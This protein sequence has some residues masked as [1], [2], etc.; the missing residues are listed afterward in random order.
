MK[1]LGFFLKNMATIVACFAVFLMLSGCDDKDPKR[2]TVT[3]NSNEGSAVSPQ[4]VEEGKRATKPD[5]PTRN[6]YLFDAWYKEASLTNQWNFNVDAVTADI[7]LHANWNELFS[8]DRF[9]A[10]SYDGSDKIKYS[11]SFSGYDFY[12]IYLG[13]MSN[14]PLFSSDP[15]FHNGM[16]S[17]LTFSIS[18]TTTSIIEETISNSSETVLMT[19]DEHTKSKTTGGRLSAETGFKIPIINIGAKT[20]AESHWQNFISNTTTTQ[21]QQT[22]SLTNTVTH[23]TNHAS[24]FTQTHRFT[25]GRDAKRGYYQYTLFGASDVYLFVIRNRETGARELDYKE[26][27]KPNTPITPRNYFWRLDYSETGTFGK[28]DQSEFELDLSILENLPEPELNFNK[29]QVSNTI[30][31]NNALTFIRDGGSDVEYT[32]T[33]SGNVAVPG[34]VTNSF[35]D[36]SNL[37]VTINSINNGKLFLN[38]QGSILRIGNGQTVNL[39]NIDL[40]GLST[41]QNGSTVNNNV[42]A[43]FI[44]GGNVTM[45]GGSIKG[46]SSPN[47]NGGGVS[48]S[49]GIL[50]IKGSA[51]ITGN[52]AE[53]GGGV[54]VEN[55]G[56]FNMLDDSSI[57]D[58]IANLGGG[59]YVH[60][61]GIFNMQDNTSLHKNIAQGSLGGGGVRI[62]GGSFRIS[63]GVVYGNNAGDMSNT[64]PNSA[65]S[66]AFSIGSGGV[67]QRGTFNSDGIFTSLGNLN[68][69]NN[70]IRIVNGL[71]Q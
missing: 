27:I 45:N 18:E 9:V 53:T 25:I 28:S 50:T 22:T 44:D 1:N 26:H 4:T 70:T 24:T 65:N 43:V 60:T 66:A 38:S 37:V 16:E 51:S 30:E 69:T 36:L 41:G 19:V 20:S 23:A 68:G 62:V 3:F 34:T 52:E 64:T 17:Q 7:T 13:E 39:N 12:Y 58:N 6:G 32:I 35:D 67:V 11:Y 47:T 42:S 56:T 5:D 15:V 46:N 2:F 8:A 54:F 49:R 10:K 29:I 59:V 61:N 71:L 14:V 33:V 63:G 21:F 55:N 31:W 48:V 40:E 57:F